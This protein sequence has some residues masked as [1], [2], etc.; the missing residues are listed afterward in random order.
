[1]VHLRAT[2]LAVLLTCAGV[3]SFVTRCEAP[4]SGDGPTLPHQA[5]TKLVAAVLTTDCGVE[6][7]DQ[8]ALAHL[9]LSPELDLRAIVTTHASSVHFSS[10]SS[11]RTAADVLSRIVPT[12]AV[13][14]PVAAGADLPLQDALTPRES[15]G[16]NLLLSLSRAFSD[17]RRLIVLSIGAATD[18]ASALLKDPSI[19][20][21]I[22][23][24]A[25]GFND[26]PDGGDEFNIR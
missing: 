6:I 17:S 22:I 23:V 19:E 9:L 21:R 3:S 25:M 7:D 2:L 18:V 5:A 8:W 13:S 15:S 24:V 16:L 26:W 20:H 1:M 14:V 4:H 11:A 12:K 10:A